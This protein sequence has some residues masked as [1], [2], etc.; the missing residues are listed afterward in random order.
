MAREWTLRRLRGVWRYAAA[1]VFVMGATLVAEVLYRVFE[2]D[3][4]SMVFLA[5]V[6]ITAGVVALTGF[7]WPDWVFGALMALLFLSTSLTVVRAAW[8]Q[9][10]ASA[11]TS[12]RGDAIS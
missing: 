5:G 10:R 6:L 8:P 1:L 12:P 3:R 11:E 4:L 2:T 7:A 9:F